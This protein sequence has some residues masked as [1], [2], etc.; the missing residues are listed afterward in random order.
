MGA[1]SRAQR[2]CSTGRSGQDLKGGERRRELRAQEAGRQ[3]KSQCNPS[4][5]PPK[6]TT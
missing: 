4:L 1:P 6:V 3:Q 5:H 2:A